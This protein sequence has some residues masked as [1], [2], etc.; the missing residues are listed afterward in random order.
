MLTGRPA[1]VEAG[2]RRILPGDRDGEA[3]RHEQRQAA[4]IRLNGQRAVVLHGLAAG[5]I[6]GEVSKARLDPAAAQERCHDRHTAGAKAQL[7]AQ[8]AVIA[9]RVLREFPAVGGAHMVLLP[10]AAAEIID[11]QAHAPQQQK[12]RDQDAPA[13]AD[14]QKAECGQQ[15]IAAH[16]H[17]ADAEAGEAV[18]QH[19]QTA[20]QQGGCPEDRPDGYIE[21]SQRIDKKQCA[22]GEDVDREPQPAACGA[23]D[24]VIQNVFLLLRLD[25]LCLVYALLLRWCA[26]E[27]LIHA[28]AE[29]GGKL[30]QN[31]DVGAGEVV[32]PFA[33]RLCAH[34]DA[35]RQLL[36]RHAQPLAVIGNALSKRSLFHC[37]FPPSCS[38][39]TIS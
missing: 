4:E 6:D 38:G 10:P 22:D 14:G 1:L 29:D 37:G 13:E 7:A 16:E 36:L 24:G 8:V 18:R 15:R 35:L 39:I 2:R 27:Q 31:G 28:D 12:D 30:R 11:Q 21:F 9:A 33:H 5:Q 26:A 20:Q 34:A 25:D 19:A 17:Q 23:A 3:V 32:L